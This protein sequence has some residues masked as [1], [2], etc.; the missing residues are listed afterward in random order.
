MVFDRNA[1]LVEKLVCPSGIGD[2][3]SKKAQNIATSLIELL[4]MSGLLAVEFFVDNDGEIMVNE[5]A[6]RP[7]NSG[8][9]TIESVITSQ[10]EQH[11]RAILNLPLGSTELKMPA[12]MLNLLGEKG[13]YGPVKY[14]GLSESMAIEGVKMHLY[15]KKSTRPF[16]KMGHVTIISKSLEESLSKA[17][18]VKKLI[19]VK[20]WG[21]NL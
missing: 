8:H 10:F 11:L 9:H 4:G 14:E 17:E 18:M 20:S 7:H 13:F 2:E 5:V 12:V 1:N 16:R 19:K 15:G 3:L 6:P 21:K